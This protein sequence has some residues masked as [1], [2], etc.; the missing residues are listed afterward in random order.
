MYFIHPGVLTE[1]KEQAAILFKAINQ[2]PEKQKTAFMLQKIQDMSQQ[3]IAEIMEL[4]E[5]AVES[6]LMRAKAN[7]KK[8]LSNYYSSI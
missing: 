6:L 3:N 1:N 2:L 5:G 8:L 4:S 7:L